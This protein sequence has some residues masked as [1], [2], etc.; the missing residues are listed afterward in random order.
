MAATPKSSLDQ[1]LIKTALAA[2]DWTTLKAHFDGIGLT[3]DQLTEVCGHAQRC[4]DLIYKYPRP[5][6]EADRARLFD[7]LRAEA[8]ARFGETAQGEISDLASLIVLTAK[9]DGPAII[10]FRFFVGL[11]LVGDI[12]NRQHGEP[13]AVLLLEVLLVEHLTGEASPRAEPEVRRGL[14]PFGEMPRLPV[15]P[16]RQRSRRQRVALPN[17]EDRAGW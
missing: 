4:T 15:R 14:E 8:V 3:R 12:I 1:E 17:I 10:E 11:V 13:V 6:A 7:E 2:L 5:K 16:C 9:S